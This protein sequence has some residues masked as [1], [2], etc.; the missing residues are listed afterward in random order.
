MA[1]VPADIK[2]NLS[3]SADNQ[4][5]A[6]LMIANGQLN[7]YPPPSWTCASTNAAGVAAASKS[8]IALGMYGADSIDG[9]MVDPGSGNA[10]AGHRRWIL[11]PYTMKMGTGG[12]WAGGRG[13]RVGAGGRRQGRA[14]EMTTNFVDRLFLAGDTDGKYPV[15]QFYSYTGSNTL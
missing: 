14:R 9:Y 5:A 15:N 6:L 7:H 3:W 1:G 12:V 8:N 10:A 4:Q 13:S 11:Y 2:I